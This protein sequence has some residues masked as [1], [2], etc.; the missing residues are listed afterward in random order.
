MTDYSASETDERLKYLD[1]ARRF[2]IQIWRENP[3]L[4]KHGEPR[5]IEMMTP[6]WEQDER[7]RDQTG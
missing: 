4:L 2:F 6:I 5:L 7:G 3:A 1:D